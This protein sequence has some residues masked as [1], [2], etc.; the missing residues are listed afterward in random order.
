MDGEWVEIKMI[1]GVVA[2]RVEHPTLVEKASVKPY[3][4]S[5]MVH[6]MLQLEYVLPLLPNPKTYYL[7]HFFQIC[8]KVVVALVI[9]GCHIIKKYFL[10]MWAIEDLEWRKFLAYNIVCCYIQYHKPRRYG[11][12]EFE[13][14]FLRFY[15]LRYYCRLEYAY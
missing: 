5:D 15:A 11:V 12:L 13:V 14:G 8:L 6:M 7:L 2:P 1:Y 3:S 4:K 10:A 9:L